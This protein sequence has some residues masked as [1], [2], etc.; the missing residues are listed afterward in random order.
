MAPPVA[1]P[2]PI[3]TQ[4]LSLAMGGLLSVKVSTDGRPLKGD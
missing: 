2:A 4:T 3:T 1:S